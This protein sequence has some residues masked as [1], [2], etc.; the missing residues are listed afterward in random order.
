MCSSDLLL[1]LLSDHDWILEMDMNDD[2]EFVL[3]R[4]EEQ[5]LDV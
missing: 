3:T 2:N 4:L 1:F 5:M